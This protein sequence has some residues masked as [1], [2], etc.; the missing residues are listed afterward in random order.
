MRA[1]SERALL[2]VGF[3][4]RLSRRVLMWGL[5]GCVGG[6][7]VGI[8]LGMVFA[9]GGIGFWMFVVAP[10]IFLGGVGAFTA[11]IASLE[12]PQ[13]GNEPSQTDAPMRN[14]RAT[15]EE[16]NDPISRSRGSPD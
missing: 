1:R 8:L 11:G 14:Q 3:V 9:N 10:A 6:I 13:P 5:C 16:R 7:G 4:P 2:R 12:S 15:V